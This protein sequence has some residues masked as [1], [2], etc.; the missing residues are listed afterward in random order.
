MPTLQRT[1]PC[2][3]FDNQAE[4]AAQ[5]YCSI[6]PNS[7]ILSVS[8]YGEAG[9]EIRDERPDVVMAVEVLHESRL[10]AMSKIAH[11]G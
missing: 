5:F 4:P 3:W 9:R 7:K 11:A 6:F 10:F 8:R 2:L 1:A